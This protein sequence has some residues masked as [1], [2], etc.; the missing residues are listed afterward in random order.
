[1]KQKRNR[2]RFDGGA[3]RYH[4]VTKVLTWECNSYFVSSSERCKG[5][6]GLGSKQ[7]FQVICSMILQKGLKEICCL[8]NR[9]PFCCIW[10][11]EH[12][13]NQGKNTLRT[14]EWRGEEIGG[15]LFVRSSDE[16]FKNTLSP[17]FKS[18]YKN[19]FVAQRPL[20]TIDNIMLCLVYYL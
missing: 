19:M 15:I 20:C 1:M 2:K 9:R 3:G 5:I 16:K 18:Y 13:K 6:T 14:K 17:Q 12:V 8:F 4:D 11:Q 7:F 10:Q